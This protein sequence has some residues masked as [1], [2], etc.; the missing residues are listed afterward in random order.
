ML[1]AASFLFFNIIT[2]VFTKRQITKLTLE[3][4]DFPKTSYKNK[5]ASKL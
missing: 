5:E 1:K 2:Y 3:A 4:E